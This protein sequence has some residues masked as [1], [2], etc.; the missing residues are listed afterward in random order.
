MRTQARQL[1]AY[2]LEILL[3]RGQNLGAPP[4]ALLSGLTNEP[5]PHRLEAL[6]VRAHRR[7]EV[8]NGI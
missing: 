7:V 3:G 1:L 2:L 6:L 4:L 8:T 5:A